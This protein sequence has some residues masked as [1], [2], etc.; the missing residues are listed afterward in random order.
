M[1]TRTVTIRMPEDV[2]ANTL[3]SQEPS[4]PSITSKGRWGQERRLEFIETRLCWDGRLN[5]SALTDFFGISVPQASLDLSRY[6]AD[7][8]G[9]TA[10][11]ASAKAYVA[12]Q[13]FQARFADESSARY[14]AELY[15]LTTHVL[16]RDI[17]FLGFIPPTEIV[18][19]PSRVVPTPYLRQ[20][21]TAIR[22]KRQLIILYQ[23]MSHPE[24]VQRTISPHALG[25][26]GFRWHIR[27][28]CH[29][30]ERYRDFVFARILQSQ[31]GEASSLDP[32][33]D[34][35][36]QTMLDVLIGP[37]PSLAEGPRRAIALDYGMKDDEL[38]IPTRQAFAYY[39][40]KRL[41][42]LSPP[43]QNP[44]EQHIIL[45]NRN[46]LR[47]YVTALG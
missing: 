32:A 42:L 6:M 34:V 31:V 28:Y 29:L 35:E 26:D 37:N 23:T 9:N 21:L 41:G 44:A 19:A 1:Y 20:T 13:D 22:D 30:R 7:A 2:V 36:W 33:D 8:P 16:G 25:Y 45:L 38:R 27:A 17:S 18:R 14:L 4:A 10:Y 40:L 12:T 5:R 24:P 15:A 47:R 43:P 3:I 39:L 46:E 11:D